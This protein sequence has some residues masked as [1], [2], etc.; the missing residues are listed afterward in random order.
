MSISLRR[1]IPN[2]STPAYITKFA[3]LRSCA[4]EVFY[5]F[6]LLSLLSLSALLQV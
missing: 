6:P 3:N 4:F 2:P 5:F 1:E